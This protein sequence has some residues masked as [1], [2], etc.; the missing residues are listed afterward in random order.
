MKQLVAP[1]IEAL[2]PYVPG[3]PIEALRRE[4]GITGEILKLASNENPLGPSP[5]ALAAVQEALTEA[6]YYPDGA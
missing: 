1:Y 6:H 5:K 2:K 3:K 4:R